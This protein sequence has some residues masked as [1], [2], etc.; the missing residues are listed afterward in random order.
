MSPAGLALLF[1]SAFL[2]AAGAAEPSSTRIGAVDY[3]SV[4]DGADRLGLRLVPVGQSALILKEGARPVAR[5]ADRS[6]EM[7]LKGLRVFLGDPVIARGGVF[8]VSRTDLDSH[9]VPRLRPELCGPPPRQPR[10]IAI[11]PGHGGTDHGAENRALGSMEKTYTLDV[12]LRL[13]KLL[14]GAGYTVVLTRDADYDLS[15]TIRSETANRANAD[16]FVSVHFNSLYPNTKTTGVEVLSFPSRSQRSADSWSPGGKDNAESKDAPINGFDAWNM[17]LAGA[18]HRRILDAL[19]DGDRGEKFE[20]LGVLRELKCPGVLVEPAFISSD[21]EAAKLA[22]PETRDAIAGA[23][24]AGIED[25]AQV[26]RALHPAAAPAPAAEGG[27][28][29]RAQPTRPAG[30]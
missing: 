17:V 10:V 21:A 11:D 20:H 30:P 1:A 12:A 16:L 5:L 29:A 6:R 4:D 22:K 9:L 26:I 25:Y 15:K 2:G 23:L 24:L 13:R 18:L 27:P 14:E 8:Y 28:A 3:V 19:H 7:D